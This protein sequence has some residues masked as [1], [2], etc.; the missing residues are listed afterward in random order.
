MEN[1]LFSRRS[2]RLAYRTLGLTLR[3]DSHRST[4]I[5]SGRTSG[6]KVLQRSNKV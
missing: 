6:I 4:A 2:V 3:F 1:S 5:S